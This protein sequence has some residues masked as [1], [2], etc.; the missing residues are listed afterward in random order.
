MH[1][2]GQR[3]ICSSDAKSGYRQ[4]ESW[5]SRGVAGPQPWRHPIR[6]FSILDRLRE[7]S[8]QNLE[9]LRN[10][11]RMAAKGYPI[12]IGTSRKSFIGKILDKPAGGR[13]WGT[14][15]SVAAAAIFGAH[16][17]RVHD[18]AEMRDVVTIVDAIIGQAGRSDN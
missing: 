8:E 3:A 4:I 7:D 2:R 5:T 14:A 10:L 9:L 17:V 11:S 16:I 12:L 15:A 13:I 18:V 6:L 1:M